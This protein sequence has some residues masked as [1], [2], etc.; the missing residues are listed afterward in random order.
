LGKSAQTKER[1]LFSLSPNYLFPGIKFRI[2][3]KA[4]KEATMLDE[5][6]LKPPS[7]LYHYT[8]AAGLLGI[9]KKE[10]HSLWASAIGFSNDSSEGRYATSAG[11]N[12]LAAYKPQRGSDRAVIGVMAT[13]LYSTEKQREAAFSVSLCQEDNL[14]SQWRAYGGQHRSPSGSKPTPF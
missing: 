5:E 2:S 4:G 7:I 11:N 9:L 10:G 12:I 14:L 13:S 8:T 1:G 3:G 6:D